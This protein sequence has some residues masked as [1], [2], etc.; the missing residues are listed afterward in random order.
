MPGRHCRFLFQ[1]IPCYGLSKLFVAVKVWYPNFNTSHVTV[2]PNTSPECPKL[3]AFQYIP[4]YGLSKLRESREYQEKSF[5]YIPCY[6]LSV[7][8]RFTQEVGENFNTSH[9]TVYRCRSFIYWRLCLISI[10]PMLRFISIEDAEVTTLN[11]FQYIPCYGLSKIQVIRTMTVMNF[12]TSH[13]TV[14]PR[15]ANVLRRYTPISIH[16]MLRFI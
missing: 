13:V 15:A 4:C 3:I 12:N 16:P 10:H 14:Y 5:Q 9:V 1:Y 7:Q 11:G 2:Y 8:E 6:G